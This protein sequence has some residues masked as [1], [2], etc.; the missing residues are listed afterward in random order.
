M[1]IFNNIIFDEFTLLE[2]EQAEEYKNRKKREQYQNWKDKQNK[3]DMRYH[4]TKSDYDKGEYGIKV[5]DTKK[6][7]TSQKAKDI[8]SKEYK[9]REKLSDDLVDKYHD[10]K[11]NNH[12]GERPNG[13]F[14]GK[15]KK[16]YDEKKKAYDE[17][18]K[19]LRNK[20]YDEEERFR[21]Y[22]MYHKE[23]KDTI[24]RH[25]RRHPKQYKESVFENIEMI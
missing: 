1:S 13:I 12:P 6:D 22:D 3:H 20:S 14:K 21:K 10:H 11:Q 7:N 15:E 8:Y 23:V 17:K 4:G 2:G 9:R 24:D 18:E 16:K 5:K 19:E 25:I